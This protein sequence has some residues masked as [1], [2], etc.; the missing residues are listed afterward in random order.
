[1][2][3]SYENDNKENKVINKLW[4]SVLKISKPIPL[5]I[6]LIQI[7]LS[8]NQKSED[9]SPSINKNQQ[10]Y[11]N[12]IP[13][14]APSR[15]PSNLQSSSMPFTNPSQSTTQPLITLPI[16]TPINSLTSSTETVESSNSQRSIDSKP[17]LPPKP[18]TPVPKGKIVF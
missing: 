6:K 18:R 9:I 16:K 17:P 15:L 1:M 10:P 5:K 4:E 2:L 12:S 14:K 7:D 3:K 8:N 13:P 11:S